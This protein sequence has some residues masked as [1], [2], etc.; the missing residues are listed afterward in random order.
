MKICKLLPEDTRTIELA[1]AGA[2]ILYFCTL[3]FVGLNPL[4]IIL[5][6]VGALQFYF[7]FSGEYTK[8]RS[9][10][11]LLA[12]YFLCHH[13]IDVLPS[14]AFSGLI[15]LAVGFGNFYAYIVNN[16]RAVWKF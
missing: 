16:P 2:M 15:S 7:L 6:I 11:S 1:S 9:I 8:Q 14:D 3:L 12:G 10:L 13:G 4:G 5:G